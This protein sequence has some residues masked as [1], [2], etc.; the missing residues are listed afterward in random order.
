MAKP[1]SAT[2]SSDTPLASESGA[3]ESPNP[4]DEEEREQ[5]QR[6]AEE[7][8]QRGREWRERAILTIHINHHLAPIKV[9]LTVADDGISLNFLLANAVQDS[10]T[11]SYGD[12]ARLCKH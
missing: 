12:I 2:P 5:E 8:A 3:E 9:K 1:A 11:P 6:K 4:R 10:V 7:R